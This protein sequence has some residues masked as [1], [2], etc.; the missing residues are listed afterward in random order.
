VV[1]GF[2]SS[3]AGLNA[4]LVARDGVAPGGL[5][6]GR[7]HQLG[8]G[9]RQDYGLQAAGGSARRADQPQLTDVLAVL[10]EYEA[11][12]PIILI[13]NRRLSDE[14]L[15]ALDHGAR[16]VLVKPLDPARLATSIARACALLT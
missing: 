11:L 8:R 15:V 10:A 6:H 9:A 14:I 4:E 5:R 16:D 3:T 12:L 2:S 1:S 7:S 13:T